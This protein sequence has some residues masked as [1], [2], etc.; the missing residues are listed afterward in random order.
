MGKKS[1]T[2]TETWFLNTFPPL[3]SNVKHAT[4]KFFA[5]V[6][7]DTNLEEIQ[8]IE[9]YLNRRVGERIAKYILNDIIIRSLT[10]P[11]YFL[12]Y[13]EYR[14]VLTEKDLFEYHNQQHY[15]NSTTVKKLKILF[16][17]VYIIIIIIII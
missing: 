5:V 15:Y 3:H 12:D 11:H 2:R 7:G 6:V 14:S 1:G 9:N 13:I 8:T 10:E 4:F 16:S 17:E